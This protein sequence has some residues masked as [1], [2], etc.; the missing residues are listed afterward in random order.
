[1]IRR[2]PLLPIALALMAGIAAQHWLPTVPHAVWWALAGATAVATGAM[3]VARRR[4]D[5][6]WPLVALIICMVTIGATLGRR[7]DPLYNTHDWSHHVAA[8]ERPEFIE[9]ELTATPTPRERSYMAKAKVRS[10][11]GRPT[12]GET[13]VYFK[14]EEAS[15]RLHYGDRLLAHC[16][17]GGER[18]TIYITS[19][20]YIITGRDS[21]SLRARSE[22]LRMRMLKRMQEGP[23]ARRQAGIDEALTLGWR[24]DV[25]KETQE[26]FRDAGIAHLLAVSGLHVGLVAGILGILCFF[27]PKTRRGRIAKGAVQLAGVWSFTLLSG[28]A[29]S[30]MRAALMFSLFITS[31]ILARRT[32]KMNLLACTALMTLAARPMLLFDVGWQLSYSAVAGILLAKPV[33]MQYKDWLWQAA[34]VSIT[35]TLATLPVTLSVFHRMQPYSLIANVA[36]VPL[37]GAVLALALAYMAVPCS[38]TAW[39]LGVTLKGVEWVTSGVATLPGAVVET[40]G[41]GPWGTLAIAVAVT[42][43]LVA[44]SRIN[45]KGYSER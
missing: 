2:A 45:G 18:K 27:V 21:T 28:M 5:S 14:R 19:D 25:E 8:T 33:I 24:A 12:E 44:A 13:K 34:T 16:Y 10:I 39:T 43:L 32:P 41:L 1:M 15:E 20:H 7:H 30:T 11:G 3:L 6:Y 31:N 4:L 37:S 38:A 35:A 29:P 22:A 40:A 9:L 42:A 36:I 17:L 23:L 26:A